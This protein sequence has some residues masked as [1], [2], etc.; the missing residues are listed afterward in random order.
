MK[1]FEDVHGTELEFCKHSSSRGYM[2][3][4]SRF[5]VAR[6]TVMSPGRWL[7]GPSGSSENGVDGSGPPSARGARAG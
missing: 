4:L 5:V 3:I 1:R 7:V 6:Y 2:R